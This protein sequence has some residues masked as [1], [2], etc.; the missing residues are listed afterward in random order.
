[1]ANVQEI[2]QINEMMIDSLKRKRNS[3]IDIAR[4]RY[5]SNSTD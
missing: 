1:M 3:L 4:N 2:I 5:L